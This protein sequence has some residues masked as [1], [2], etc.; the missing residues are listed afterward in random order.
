MYRICRVLISLVVAV[1]LDAQTYT[2]KT[3]AGGG[4]PVNVPGTAASLG[5][6]Y[7]VALDASGNAFISLKPPTPRA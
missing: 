1:A 4:L 3:V 7:G 6:P 2:I 5:S